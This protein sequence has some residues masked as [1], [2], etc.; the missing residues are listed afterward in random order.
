M[1]KKNKKRL[2]FTLGELS[3]L[4]GKKV[5]VQK[6]EDPEKIVRG[7]ISKVDPSEQTIEVLNSNKIERFYLPQVDLYAG[8]QKIEISYDHKS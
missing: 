1:G 2:E 4:I 8:A 6:R 3:Q 7:Y 5:T